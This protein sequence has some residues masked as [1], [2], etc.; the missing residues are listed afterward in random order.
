MARGP[1]SPRRGV[2]N[3]RIRV[4]PPGRSV[5]RGAIFSNKIRAACLSPSNWITRRRAFTAGAMARA[6]WF[7]WSPARHCF[8]AAESRSAVVPNWPAC[9]AA[10]RPCL[11]TVTHR[12]TSGRTSL[13]FATVVTIRPR[14]LAA[15]SS[16]ASTSR[17]VS[18]SADA[19]LRSNARWCEGLRPR[20]RPFLRW[21]MADSLNVFRCLKWKI[22]RLRQ[23][24][25][26]AF[27]PAGT[28]I[29]RWSP[30]SRSFSS[31]SCSVVSPKF[32]TSSSSSRD[33]DTRSRRDSMPAS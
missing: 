33:R 9:W 27:A 26:Q 17:S 32:R 20:T 7:H 4:Y 13:A 2:A 10:T 29:P 22:R 15:P 28:S 31:I 18:M 16:P 14:T 30:N 12:S 23:P 24:A 19:R 1:A 11:A 6:H 3:L 8:Q 21:R 25:G 5:N